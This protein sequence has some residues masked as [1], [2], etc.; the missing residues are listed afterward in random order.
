MSKLSKKIKQL[1]RPYELNDSL[2]RIGPP[3]DGG[4][5]INKSTLDQSDV[6]YSYGIGWSSDFEEEFVNITNKFANLYDHTI[7]SINLSHK[8][9]F[10]KEG[11]SG[12]KNHHCDN[13]LNHIN[14]NN[15]LNKNILSK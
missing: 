15:D 14:R 4:Y 5:I 6:L 10:H 1:V 13:V 8:M 9:R 7:D 12:I 3:C 11:L 2:I